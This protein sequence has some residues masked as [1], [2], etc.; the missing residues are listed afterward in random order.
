MA[1]ILIGTSGWSYAN[2]KGAFY[3]NDL[4]QRDWLRYYATQFSSVEINSTFYHVPSRAT[5]EQWRTATPDDFV[6]SL[7]LSRLITH[8]KH[9]VA[10][11]QTREA[12]VRFF[13][14][15]SPLKHKFGV[16][17]VQL[18]A[19]LHANIQQLTTFV[20]ILK[21]TLADYDITPRIAIEFRH[22]S[23]FTTET[24]ALLRQHNIASVWNSGPPTMPTDYTPTAD[25]V[26]ARFHG[27]PE[28]YKSLYSETEMQH[29]AEHFAH[30]SVS[31]LF[32]YFNNTM[33]LHA[34]ANAQQLQE[35][36]K[37]LLKKQKLRHNAE[38]CSTLW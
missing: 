38:V 26:Y 15:T 17:L 19:S 24:F 13:D 14:A 22:A 27:T 20:Q 33:E 31:T 29:W 6:F 1:N 32:A 35:N 10:D 21:E 37:K 16:L 34:I 2:W 25:F 28:L 18:P 5:V 7:K 11:E 12:L 9:L 36:I 3:P 8:M 4:A 30:T 23:W